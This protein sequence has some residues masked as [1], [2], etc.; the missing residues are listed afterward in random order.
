MADVRDLTPTA[1]STGIRLRA[2]PAVSMTVHRNAAPGRPVRL[3]P[4][5]FEYHAAASRSD[6][7]GFSYPFLLDSVR[8]HA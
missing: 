4:V 3:D 2:G 5:R 8:C 6:K 7:R 1:E